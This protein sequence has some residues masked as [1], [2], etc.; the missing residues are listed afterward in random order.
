MVTIH[1]D[2]EIQDSDVLSVAYNNAGRFGKGVYLHNTSLSELVKSNEFLS[3]SEL[4]SYESLPEECKTC[5]YS[6]ICGG[7]LLPHRY[8]ASQMFD[9]P[10]VY[11]ANMKYLINH[12]IRVVSKASE[13]TPPVGCVTDVGL[14]DEKREGINSMDSVDSFLRTWDEEAAI[15]TIKSDGASSS[16]HINID[17]DLYNPTGEIH[18]PSERCFFEAIEAGVKELVKL[19]VLKFGVVTYSSCEGH[20]L[21]DDSIRLRSVGLLPR[22]TDERD[23][24]ISFLKPVA[25]IANMASCSHV[26]VIISQDILKSDHQFYETVEINFVPDV[27]STK[28]YFIQTESSYKAFCLSLAYFLYAAEIENDP[29]VPIEPIM[30]R[31]RLSSKLN[32]TTTNSY[33]TMKFNSGDCIERNMFEDYTLK[34]LC[35]VN[36]VAAKWEHND[37]CV[38]IS[39]SKYLNEQKYIDSQID[40]C[41]DLL[42]VYNHSWAL[43]AWLKMINLAEVSNIFDVTVTHFDCH[44]DLSPPM[45]NVTGLNSFTDIYSEKSIDLLLPNTVASAISS[46]A[47]GPGQFILP[48]LVLFPS[49]IVNLVF[50]MGC[51]SNDDDSFTQKYWRVSSCKMEGISRYSI[52]ALKDDDCG[53]IQI[54][55]HTIEKKPAISDGCFWIVDI[56]CDYFCN[57]YDELSSDHNFY[58]EIPPDDIINARIEQVLNYIFSVGRSPDIITIAMSPDFCPPYIGVRIINRLTQKLKGIF[59]R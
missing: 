18:L 3:R 46:G 9:N 50:P 11:C 14:S 21:P 16:S 43:Y 39:G 33:R 29:S 49:A 41:Q 28:A 30:Q 52:L 36:V 23:W 7:G 56:D 40:A 47:I 45:L 26:G 42:V 25:E 8:S 19:L 24:I 58:K 57:F 34:A 54:A 32:V 35:N 4:Y 27:L 12:I 48:F 53:S 1:T 44:S 6:K 15:D 59:S 31:L 20:L 22:S 13:V 10:S 17:G 2:G 5:E 55:K 38:T 37:Y 51:S